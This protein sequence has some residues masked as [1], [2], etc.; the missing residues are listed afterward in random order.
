M[1]K[2]RAAFIAGFRSI[3]VREVETVCGDDEVIVKVASCGLCNFELNHFKLILGGG[4]GRIGHEAAGVIVEVGR[5]VIDWKIGDRVSASLILGSFADYAAVPAADL[6]R[7]DDHIDLTKVLGEPLRCIITVVSAANPKP[8]DIG[9]IV[10]AGPM[11]LWCV[12]ALSKGF[13][14]ELIVIDIN[15]DNLALAAKMGATRT[16]NSAKEDAVAKVSEYT[17]GRMADFCIEGTGVPEVLLPCAHYLRERGRLILSSS[18]EREAKS[19]DLRLI[20]GKGLTLHGAHPGY[21]ADLRDDF[22]RAAAFI[23]KGIFH[24]DDIITHTFGLSQIQQAF[25]TLDN[26][27]K[28]YIKGIVVPELDLV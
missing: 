25:E 20:T 22:V 24:M 3:E 2:G 9:V 15:D 17:G 21:S 23:N 12:Q 14:T 19:A 5:N 10:G 26:K 18:H 4:D 6:E 1:Q 28:G 7:I 11:G 27:P 13:L 8:G 16:I